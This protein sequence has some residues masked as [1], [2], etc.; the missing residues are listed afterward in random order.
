MRP[1][2]TRERGRLADLPFLGFAVY[3]ALALLMISTP[4]QLGLPPALSGKVQPSD[5]LFP[6]LLIPWLAAGAPGWRGA[7]RLAGA[8][9]AA[10]LVAVSVTAAVAVDPRRAWVEAVAFAYLTCVLV[11]GASVLAD[12]DRLLAFARAWVWV[13]AVVTVLGLAGVLVANVTS[14]PNFLV[15]QRDLLLVG[16]NFRVR[17][18]LGPTS[19]LLAT[20]LILILPPVFALRALEGDRRRRLYDGFLW[21]ALVCEL[22]TF[23][24]QILE[25]AFVFGLFWLRQFPRSRRVGLPLLVGAYLLGFLGVLAASTWYVTHLSL[26][27]TADRSVIVMERYHSTA[28]DLGTQIGTARIEYIHDNYFLLKRAAWL[29]FKERPFLGW[30]PDSYRRLLPRLVDAG[31]LP[32]GFMLD[33]AQSEPFSVAAEMGL[34]GLAAL[35]LFWGLLL[36]AMWAPSGRGLA[37][38]LA[39]WQTLACGAV[40]VTSL[41]LDVMRFRFLW[42][43]LAVGLAAALVARQAETSAAGAASTASTRG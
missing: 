19:K 36:R 34:V 24:R 15:Y 37:G 39:R 2:V 16:R 8:P 12:R 27:W 14:R 29:L 3:C 21:T 23:S 6:A 17:S 43:S 22:L 7:V 40:L 18:T 26:D 31:Y 25:F 11:W 41:H 38:D 28:P 1:I 20:L 13:V 9:A 42:I 10:W 30:G 33:S 35:T 32:P 4:G 5:L